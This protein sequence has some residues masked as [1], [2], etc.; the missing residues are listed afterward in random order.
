VDIVIEGGNPNA[1]GVVARGAQGVSVQDC[2]ITM[3]DAAVGIQGGAGSGGLLTLFIPN[4][5]STHPLLVVLCC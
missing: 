5:S 4:I 3:V 1:I 2:T